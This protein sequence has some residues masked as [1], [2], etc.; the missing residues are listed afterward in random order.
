M[1][2]IKPE[3]K[4]AFLSSD[5]RSSF[6]YQPHSHTPSLTHS[7]HDHLSNPHACACACILQV[8]SDCDVLF[9]NERIALWTFFRQELE[10]RFEQQKFNSESG[11]SVHDGSWA[12][13]FMNKVG[14]GGKSK[15]QASQEKDASEHV[16]EIITKMGGKRRES[17][18]SSHVSQHDNHSMQVIEE[19]DG[20]GKKAVGGGGV[21]SGQRSMTQPVS[22]NSITS[23][24]SRGTMD[25]YNNGRR[26]SE[27]GN[28]DATAELTAKI[29]QLS[30]FAKL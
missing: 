21:G 20:E 13:K 1:K 5:V 10:K 17:H 26:E 14:R 27:Y 23:H 28:E 16:S 25:Q 7:F 9:C 6:L 2:K 18:A 29:K 24:H 12:E 22:R 19:T 4:A 3:V 30:N 8:P 11:G 15:S